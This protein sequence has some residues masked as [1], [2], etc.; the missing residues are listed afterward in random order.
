MNFRWIFGLVVGLVASIIFSLLGQAPSAGIASPVELFD[1]TPEFIQVSDRVYVATGYA[2]GNA[3][4]IIT[5]TGIVT[6][7]TTE[8]QV[9][10]RKIELKLRQVSDL[11]I[12]HI[13]YTHHHGDHIL[14]AKV[15]ANENTRIIAQYSLPTEYARWNS[16]RCYNLN[17]TILQFGATLPREERGVTLGEE[18]MQRLIPAAAQCQPTK[19]GG[20]SRYLQ[21]DIIF[22]EF[23]QFEA[24]GTRF[25]LYHTQGETRDHLMVWMPKEKM[26]FPGDLFYNSFPMLASPMKPDRPV[27]KWA[28]SLERMRILKP[29]YLIPSHG[30]PI[31]GNREIDKVLA[32]YARAIR[33]VHDETVKGINQGLSLE[34]IRQ[35][36]RLPAELAKLPYLQPVYGKVEWAVNGIYRQYT[37]WYD[38]NPTSLNPGSK[39]PFYQALLSA[40]GGSAPLLVEVRN[41]IHLEQWQL[42]LQLTDAILEVEPDNLDA[43]EMR[44]QALAKLAD[45]TNNGV[46]INIY[47]GAAQQHGQIEALG[48]QN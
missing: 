7:D 31:Q 13:I 30:K 10:A 38:L 15:F 18:I 23:Y 32:N 37:G 2:L 29:E 43:Q 41:A 21:P 5:D 40:S 19:P 22:H 35:Q 48:K 3:I 27:L 25:E 8:S 9:A 39:K 24:G 16:V 47:R 1:Q 34:Q 45:A 46:E 11:P 20:S 28:E 42:V 33:Y 44:W 26:L 14:G 6:I 12:T 17:H 4:F 36:V